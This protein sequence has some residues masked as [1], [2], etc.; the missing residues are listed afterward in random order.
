V[1]LLILSILVIFREI[2]KEMILIIY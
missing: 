2:N 1:R